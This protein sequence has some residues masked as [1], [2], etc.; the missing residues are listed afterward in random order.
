[1]KKANFS[2]SSVARILAFLFLVT[3]GAIGFQIAIAAWTG[4]TA[5]P[6]GD[7]VAAPVNV[8]STA[9]TKSGQLIIQGGLNINNSG[10]ANTAITS[11]ASGL[12]INGDS[13]G[14]GDVF[15]YE[16][17]L[18]MGSGKNIY[19]LNSDIYINGSI[20]TNG[21]VLTQTASGAQWQNAVGGGAPTDA[22]YVVL[23]L[24]G[25]LTGERVLTAGTGIS[26]TDG[27]ANG[28]IT[29]TNTGVTSTQNII[30]NKGLQRDASNNFG[31]QNCATDQIM[32][33]N[34]S[35]QW[36]CAAD[37]GGVTGSGTNNYITQWTGT[38]TVGNSPFTIN[39]SGGGSI[40]FA[41]Y[42]LGNVREIDPVFNIQG[43]K[44][45]TYLPDSIGQKI[46]VIGQSQ[47][48]KRELTI[49]LAKQTEGSDLWLFW[50][51][52]DLKS[53]VPFVSSQSNAS[54]YAYM[55]DSKLIVKSR[56][57]ASNAKF[58]YRLIGTRIDH[59]GELNNLYSDQNTKNYIDLDVLNK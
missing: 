22:S 42:K 18:Y 2:V 44:Y 58:S 12:S 9:Q 25:T 57:G 7:N 15:I 36:V 4:P 16:T 27:G 50:H 49:D 59:S 55:N 19:L 3:V 31:I 8:G 38:S 29:I 6:P 10:M 35:D 24:N 52:V 21:Q 54:L 14:L 43:K 30:T 23:G 41:N 17:G 56:D 32:K 40:D 20:G 26:I 37:A 11:V 39:T 5:V 53:V 33:Y 47:L 1:M 45:V 46:E 34:S 51:A 28:N 48:K 13:T